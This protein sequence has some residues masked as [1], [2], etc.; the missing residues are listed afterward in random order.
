MQDTF[1]LSEPELCN[2]LNPDLKDNVK[3]AHEGNCY[4]SIGYRYNWEPEEA[5]KNIMR[6]HTT[7]CSARMLLALSKEIA[8]TKVFTPKKYFSIDKVFRNEATDATHLYE[9][10]QVEGLI[11]DTKVSL[12]QLMGIIAEFFKRLGITNVKFKPTYNPY[13]EPSME[14]YGYHPILKKIV[15][16]GNSGVFRPEMLLPMGLPE[17]VNVIAWGLSLERP[18]MINYKLDN[19]RNLLGHQVP[20]K[21]VRTNPIFCLP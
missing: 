21:F 11:A 6:T 9:F 7:P 5:R 8:K 3:K 12:K 2:S 14:I 13:T 17:N 18:A 16:I 20:L 1:F 4:G 19:I 15:E 10:H